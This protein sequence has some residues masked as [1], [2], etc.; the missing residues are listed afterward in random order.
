LKEDERRWLKGLP[1]FALE[2]VRPMTAAQPPLDCSD[3]SELSNAGRGR[4]LSWNEAI[5]QVRSIIKSSQPQFSFES[6]E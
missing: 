3:D 4:Q 5:P 2:D 1:P 6:W